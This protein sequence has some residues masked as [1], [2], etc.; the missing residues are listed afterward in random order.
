[1]S[2]LS[3]ASQCPMLCLLSLSSLTTDILLIFIIQLSFENMCDVELGF[4]IFRAILL[5]TQNYNIQCL[6]YL[7]QILVDKRIHAL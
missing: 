3:R 4:F 5:S 7:L 2:S 6:A 1:M